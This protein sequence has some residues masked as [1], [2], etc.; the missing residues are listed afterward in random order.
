[1]ICTPTLRRSSSCALAICPSPVNIVSAISSTSWSGR[2]PLLCSARETVPA[3]PGAAK[4]RG[5]GWGGRGGGGGGG[6]GGARGGGGGGARPPRAAPAAGEG[7]DLGAERHGQP[8]R[9]GGVE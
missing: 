8:A 4:W 2:R 9:L 7:E 5:G 6:W 1:M 3:R